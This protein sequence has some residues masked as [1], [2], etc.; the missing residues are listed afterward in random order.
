MPKVSFR[1]LQAALTCDRPK[2]L[3]AAN[4]THEQAT[5]S[6][7]S[8]ESAW[9]IAWSTDPD[10]DPEAQTTTSASNVSEKTYTITGLNPLTDYYVA[11]QSACGGDWSRKMHFKTIAVAVVVG[12]SWSDDFE[13]TECGWELINGEL[14]NAWTWG[15]ATNNGGTH[16]LYISNDGGSTNAYTNDSGTMVYAIKLLSFTDGKYEFSY[17]WKAN[18]ENSWD[19]MRVFLVPATE[20]LTAGSSTPSGF[21]ATALPTG[22]IALDGGSKLNLATTTTWQEE[23]AIVKLVAGNYFLVVAWRN[24]GSH[25]NNPPAAID[26]VSISRMACSADVENLA[27]SNVTTNSAQITWTADEATQWQVAYSTSSTFENATE[28]IVNTASYNLTGLQ[29]GSY[30]YVKVRA[31]CG[32]SD[33]GTWSEVLKF[34]TEVETITAYPWTENFDS[35][36]G[37]TSGSTNNLPIGW[38][39]INTCTYNYYSG[40]PVIYNSYNSSYS[41]SGNNHLRFDSYQ[42]SY[43]NYDPQDQY[44]I[45]PEMESLSGKRIKLYARKDYSSSDAT[46]SVGIMTDPTDATTFTEIATCTPASTTY[47]P[48]SVLLN[49]YTG[50]GTYIAIKMAAATT[51]TNHEVLIDDIT[52]QDI[53]TCL[54]PSYLA[55]TDITAHTATL[56]WIN[57]EEG[58]DAWQICLN[59]DETN[60]INANSNPFTLTGLNGKTTYTA[61][62]RAYCSVTDQSEWSDPVSFTT[63][64]ACPVPTGLVVSA[65]G[66]NSATLNWESHADSWQICVNGDEEHPID[67]TENSYTL[68]GLTTETDYAV[69]V[70][71]YFGNDGYSSWTTNVNFTTLVSNPVPADMAV[72]NITSTAATVGWTGYGDSYNFRCRERVVFPEGFEDGTLPEGWTIEGDNQDASTTWR[73]GVGD[74]DNSTDTHSGEKNVLITHKERNNETYLITPAMNFS[75]LSDLTLSFW[76]IN[77]KWAN[78]IDGL[79]VYYRVNGGAWNELWSTTEAHETWTNQ[80]VALT[81]L[82]ANYQIGFKMTDGYGKGVGLDDIDIANLVAHDWVTVADLTEKSTDITGLTPNTQYMYQVQSVKGGTTTDWSKSA[83]FTTLG[84]I[85]LAD[86]DSAKPDGEKNADLVSDNNGVKTDVTLA[87]RTL[88]KDGGWNT[89]CLPFNL[90]I[91][92]SVLDGDNVD[93]RTLSSADYSNGTMTLNFTDKGAVT[94]LVAGTP[95]IIK[96]SKDNPSDPDL[97]NL[98]SPT[99]TGVTISNTTANA[100]TSYVDFKG[101]Y[102][103]VTYDSEDRSILFLGTENKLHY[104]QANASINAFRAYFELKNG[105]TAGDTNSNAPVQNFVLNFGDSETTGIVSHPSPLTSHLS[106]WYDLSGRKLNG[107]PTQKGVYIFGNKQVVIK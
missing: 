67:V 37:V 89:L 22:W 15:T 99:F 93:V 4:I 36:T 46:F 30:Y 49:T 39:Y 65:V 86:N 57:G 6:W 54:E 32:G 76:Y 9:N 83:F 71:G 45:L 52:V 14:T 87:G 79:G 85:E 59:D 68:T 82:D 100:E 61:K 81:G 104:P 73:V 7:T 20:T 19:Y 106:G 23:T 95:Y 5:I 48:F 17:D 62:V 40:Y 66:P 60:L 38:H 31:Y 74:Y 97:T 103:P 91:S 28:V 43:T 34:N 64:I 90:T 35:Y 21:S 51:G 72:S 50:S 53:P 33:F 78:D 98:A 44:A 77:R 58:Q 55:A 13:G 107:K 56:S 2:N 29:I 41:H 94:K 27:A 96:W 11:V 63:V 70:R 75:G 69:K 1:F 84:I 80:T 10:F 24:D 101:T 102:S 18:G 8:E 26:N 3:V 16:A 42:S 92:G 105:L 25:G 12:N 47:E 88:W